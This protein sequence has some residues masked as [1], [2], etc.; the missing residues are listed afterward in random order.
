MNNCMCR[1]TGHCSKSEMSDTP[2]VFKELMVEMRQEQHTEI[3]LYQYETMCLSS[4]FQIIF[5]ECLPCVDTMAGAGDG[6][7]PGSCP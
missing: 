2:L 3:I 6:T 4:F 1:I 5:I 7:R